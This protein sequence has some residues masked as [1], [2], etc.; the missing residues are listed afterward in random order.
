MGFSLKD[1]SAVL[2]D[3]DGVLYDSMPNHSKAWTQAMA[4]FGMNMTVQ[5]VY[6]NEGATGRATVARIS[7]NCRGCE[8]TEEEERMIYDH[9]AELFRSMPVAPVM[10]GA[11]EVMRKVKAAGLKI[12]IVTGSGQKNL[13]ERVQQDF[14]GF[15][16]RDRMVTSFDVKRG[17]PF[18]DPYLKGLEIAGVDASRAVVVENAPLGVHAAVAAGIDTI[19]VNTGP[20][21][22]EVL[23]AEK[24]ATLFSS[25]QALSDALDEML[26]APKVSVIMPVYNSEDCLAATMDSIL[27]QDIESFELIAVNDGST[28]SSLQILQEYAAKDCRVKVLTQPNGRQGRARNYGLSVARGEFVTYIDS[29]DLMSEGYLSTLYAAAIKADADIAM[30]ELKRIK[31]ASVKYLF[32]FD[33]SEEAVET[34]DKLRICH[35]P[36]SFFCVN[37][38]VRR[39]LIGGIGLRFPE[40]VY[41][42]D[43]T[44][45][46]RL[47]C[48]S[49]KLVTVPGV[50]YIYIHHPGS[51]VHS[52]QSAAKQA[53]KYN[54]HMEVIRLAR[55]YGVTLPDKFLN[56]TKR[57]YTA[58][59]VC[60]LKIKEKDGVETF[61]LF[62]FIP[63]WRRRATGQE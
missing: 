20:L 1:K 50:E 8:T 61:R 33:K 59:P 23:L 2:F 54:A 3:M 63:V 12:L 53:G 24:P 19:A 26:P 29:D 25:M 34:A 17:K 15:I 57:Y 22:D 30:C 48:N 9:K 7:M 38:I 56:V 36:P 46:F 35:C 10:P 16:T 43:A 41:Y 52:R 18:P 13:I 58:G 55:E 27:A 45:V 47:L 62:D 32:K 6:M 4:D 40:G 37:M 60:I 44:Y 39:S 11:L 49:G 31:G 5:D 21:D 42:E 14:K 28:D 51:T